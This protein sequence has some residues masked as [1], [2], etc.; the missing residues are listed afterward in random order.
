M[1]AKL[2]GSW[3]VTLPLVVL[4]VAYVMFVYLPGRKALAEL[5]TQIENKRQVLD[6]SRLQLQAIVPTQLSLSRAEQYVA[7]WEKAAP[8]ISDTSALFGMIHELANDSN[9]VTTRF[10]PDP[11]VKRDTLTQ[12]PVSF[13][14][15]GSFADLFDFLTKLESLPIRIWV[16]MLKVNSTGKNTQ[17]G[18]KIAVAIK[19][20][21]FTSNSENSD[22]VKHAEQPIN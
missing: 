20:V 11:P 17:P 19:L 3:M 1:K 21:V 16:E 12:I 10:D 8:H 22:Y 5:Q 13:D 15:S 2:G 4:A 18:E 6:R 9:L 14:V 7:Q